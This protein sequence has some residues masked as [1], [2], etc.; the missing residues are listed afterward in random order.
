MEGIPF[1][2][3]ALT[4]TAATMCAEAHAHDDVYLGLGRVRRL[5][6]AENGASNDS[7]GKIDSD[8]GNGDGGG[9][10]Q[11]QAEL[12]KQLDDKQEEIRTRQTTG[13]TA[14]LKI[15]DEKDALKAQLFTVEFEAANPDA[16]PM[17]LQK[18]LL[19]QQ[20]ADCKDYNLAA[21]F[22]DHHQPDGLKDLEAELAAFEQDNGGESYKAWKRTHLQ[23]KIDE[24]KAAIGAFHADANAD[25]THFTEANRIISLYIPMEEY[26]LEKLEAELGGMDSASSGTEGAAP[27]EQEGEETS[28]ETGPQDD[29]TGAQPDEN[30]F[31]PEAPAANV[32][33]DPTAAS[34]ADLKCSGAPNE[35]CSGDPSGGQPYCCCGSVCESNGDCCLNRAEVC[36]GG[37]PQ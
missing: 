13:T 9:A 20:I 23:Q 31:V 6:K 7:A 22:N 29:E 8:S 25:H 5:L 35:V 18:A 11:T 10:P 2:L 1:A 27:Q 17:D 26:E 12:Q 24:R 4:V 37:S 21:C 16:S 14:D 28:E 3:L 33:F 30:G 19:Q 32:S 15:R 36:D 34:C